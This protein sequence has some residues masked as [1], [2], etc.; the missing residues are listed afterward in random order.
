MAN[1]LYCPWPRVH[2]RAG[3]RIVRVAPTSMVIEPNVCV[4]VE[5]ILSQS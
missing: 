2:V 4:W 5:H 3:G 1:A